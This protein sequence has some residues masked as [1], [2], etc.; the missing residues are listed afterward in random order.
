MPIK[1][2][3][4]AFHDSRKTDAL[5]SWIMIFLTLS[6]VLLYASA[7]L[8]WFK[9]LADEKMA[10]RL[11]PIIFVVVGYCFGRLP[12]QQSER[13]LKDEISRHAKKVD[14]VQQ[15]KEQVLQTLAA[16]EEKVKN[17]TATL[18]PVA[19]SRERFD[20]RPER[21][22]S[23]ETLSGSVLVAFDILNS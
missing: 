20:E 11:E 4:E 5:R 18:A 16:L 2:A 6:L 19:E 8:G 12:S 22:E 13:A 17:V 10:V 3:A 21:H 1:R 9:P 7:L 14:A 23:N 15:S